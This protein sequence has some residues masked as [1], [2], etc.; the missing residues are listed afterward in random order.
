MN[1]TTLAT[2]R[3]R[4]VLQRHGRDLLGIGTLML[5]AILF[6]FPALLNANDV[7]SDAAVIGLQGLHLWRG[8]WS[9]HVWNAPYQGSLDSALVGICLA[10]FGHN[11][12]ALLLLPLF[13][14]LLMIGV[15]Y[16]FLRQWLKQP[17][18]MLCLLPL[19]FATMAINSPMVYIMRQTLAVVLLLTV[20]AMAVALQPGR[21]WWLTVALGLALLAYWIDTFAL[22]TLAAFGGALGF[23]L[24]LQR[25]ESTGARV[26]FIFVTLASGV[27]VLF[28]R[29]HGTLHFIPELNFT[30]R[31]R[32]SAL[33][34]DICL[35]FAIGQKAFFSSFNQTTTEWLSPGFLGAVRSLAPLSLGVGVLI[36]LKGM[37]SSR[38]PPTLRFLTLGALLTAA[39]SMFLFVYT[40][41]P[42]DPWSVR[43]LAPLVW[44]LPLSLA[45]AFFVV[46][47]RWL[48]VV[49]LPY[50]CS[51]AISGWQSFG[52][53]LQDWKPVQIAHASPQ[54]ERALLAFLTEQHVEAAAA[55]YW[56]AYGLTFLFDEKLIVVPLNPG[57]DRYP[58]FRQIFDNAKRKALVFHPSE[59]RATLP[60]Y[61]QMLMNQGQQVSVHAVAGF[62]VLIWGSA[63]TF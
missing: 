43:Y 24:C 22:S 31:E 9:S 48:A 46:R 12:L 32:T 14:M 11:A 6:R 58:P 47:T 42:A 27:V 37:L 56:L 44:F 59:P 49:L 38:C 10:V 36:A 39:A 53:Y 1:A 23:S 4:A 7:N 18:T 57:E 60:P 45:P 13:G 62:D 41:F 15:F 34:L 54:D 30:A 20:S 33:F 16:V 2:E 28:L 21:R 55:Q 61:Q 50:F 40:D 5:L 3:L 25:L 17:A 26:R 52:R 63:S 8:E 51:I 19:V 35:P 29:Q